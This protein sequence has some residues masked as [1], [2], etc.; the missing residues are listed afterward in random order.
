MHDHAVLNQ[1]LDHLFNVEWVAFSPLFTSLIFAAL[2]VYFEFFDWALLFAMPERI[3][4]NIMSNYVLLAVPFFIFMG[5]ML[6]RSKLAEDL[7]KTI[8]MLFGPMRGG[9]ALAVVFIFGTAIIVMWLSRRFGVGDGL[10]GIMGAG[11]GVCGGS[12]II[13]TAHIP[14]SQGVSRPARS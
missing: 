11:T 10:G 2:G 12:A 14:A 3:F 6:E 4:G 1:H 13:A 9:L 7:L 8:G 5:T